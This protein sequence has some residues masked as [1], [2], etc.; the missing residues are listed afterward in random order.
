MLTTMAPIHILD[1]GLGTSLEDKYGVKFNHS[2]PLWSSHF[3]I[4]NQDTLLSCQRDFV[5]A[6][7]DVLLTATYQVSIESFARTKTPDFPNGIPKDSITPYLTRAV[8]I[9]EQASKH[10]TAE[11][12]LSLGPYGASMVP[13]QEYGGKYDAEHDTEESLYQWHLERLRLFAAVEKLEKRVQYIAF[14]TLP[15]LDEIRAVR[16]AAQAAGVSTREGGPCLW[17]SCVFPAE[18]ENLPDGST[19]DQVVEAML[20][21]LGDGCM[22]WGIGVNCTKIHK[23]PGLI[24]K[25]EHAV[26]KLHIVDPL[27]NMPTLVLYPDGTNGEVYNTTTKRWEKPNDLVEDT[28]PKVSTSEIFR[29]FA[30]HPECFAHL[31]YRN[32]GKCSSLE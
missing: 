15:R 2:Q 27:H 32:P 5:E 31:H 28:Q 14:E 11:L 19:I 30:I 17:I 18:T 4:E 7:A 3:L 26:R 21:R 9:A 12:A 8:D 22:P 29:M 25:F 23:L 24:Q 20:G 16:R 1:G 13:G 6:G 10:G